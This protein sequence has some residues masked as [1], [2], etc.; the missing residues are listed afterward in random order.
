MLPAVPQ[1]LQGDA[2][3]SCMLLNFA[4]QLQGLIPVGLYLCLC[5]CKGLNLC[6]R[7]CLDLRESLDLCL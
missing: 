6:L 2:G 3:I 5:H 1:S 4:R 7:L